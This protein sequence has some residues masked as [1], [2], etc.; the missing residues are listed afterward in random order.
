MSAEEQIWEMKKKRFEFLRQCYDLTEGDDRKV[1][2]LYATGAELRLDQQLTLK[3]ARYLHK[4]GLIEF[5]GGGRIRI[6][7]RGIVEIEEAH[8]NPAKPTEHFPALNVIYV[9][10]MTDSQIQQAS[11]VATQMAFREDKYGELEELLQLLRDSIDELALESQDKSD[12]QSDIQTIEAQTTKSK[13]SRAIITE[14]LRSIRSVLEK[15]VASVLAQAL[16]QRIADLLG[17]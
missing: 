4:E 16:L 6:L 13:P 10:E 15:L 7:H 9:G 3:I 17:Q 12:L 5:Q 1:F 11:P 2:D 14:S 8:A